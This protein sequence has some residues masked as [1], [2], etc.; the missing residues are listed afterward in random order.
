MKRTLLAAG[1]VTAGYF[2][3]AQ[4]IFNGGTTS[5][6]SIYRDGKTGFGMTT[7]PSTNK[8]EIETST[9]D[10]GLSISQ[11]S[12]SPGSRGAAAIYMKN[13]TGHNW[14]LFSMGTDNNI[15][16]THFSIYDLTTSVPRFFISGTNGY[17]GI[18]TTTP[19]QML[20]VAGNINAS[21]SLAAGSISTGGG[22]S[23]GSLNTSGGV[24]VNGNLAVGSRYNLTSSGT[25]KNSSW[26]GTGNRLLLTDAGGNVAP[27]TAG[28]STQV[29]YGNGTWGNLPA[30]AF[31]SV[32]SDLNLATG[33]LGIGTASPASALDV[34]GDVHLSGA[35]KVPAL[36]GGVSYDQIVYVDNAGNFKVG[37]SAASSAAPG[38]CYPNV[39][40]WFD[41]GNIGT[42]Y[43]TIGTCD[44]ADFVLKSNATNLIWLNAVN[45][46]VGVGNSAPQVMLDVTGSGRVS[47]NLEIGTSNAN[48][49]SLIPVN[50]TQAT[51]QTGGVRLNI[52]TY[53]KTAFEVALQSTPTH[54]SFKTFCDGRTY[55]GQLDN[56]TYDPHASILTV[57]QF[58]K[59]DKAFNVVDNSVSPTP[60]DMFTIYG[61]GST[62]IKSKATNA[63]DYVFT[64]TDPVA[65]TKNFSVRKDG[66]VSIGDYYNTAYK[67]TV[68]GTALFTEAYVMLKSA[69]PDYVFKNDYK[70]MPLEKLEAY[71]K[72]NH[73]LPSVPSE[74]NIAEKGLNLGEVSK[75]Q[76]EK[77]EELTLY[78]IELKKEV[79]AL[80]KEVSERSKK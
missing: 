31:V 13:A 26:A 67:L 61:S 39:T 62:E 78:I 4:T 53:S 2:A 16:A 33:K 73:H 52:D 65:N 6:V 24:T 44:N 75:V 36:P 54:S 9:A 48:L 76:M 30:E 7:A 56:V 15:G 34:T 58:S 72:A 27:L 19:S 46:N 57:A 21:G 43:N 20:D 47:T 8:V 45:H 80:K 5:S 79:D 42:G 10:D 17:V 71:V 69:W 25:F 40:P 74:S 35:L 63:S 51:P 3:T 66:T 60:D 70:L 29:L 22:I 77:I 59:T 38:P 23:A 50:I 28:S 11:K 49:S 68:N 41:G 64:I 1:L 37:H 32:G 12:T 18:G 14:G 55:L